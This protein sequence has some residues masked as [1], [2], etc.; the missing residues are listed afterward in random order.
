MNYF[1]NTYIFDF[2]GTIADTFPFFV[3]IASQM[4]LNTGRKAT[5]KDIELF[6]TTP[7]KELIKIYKLPLYKIPLFV[8]KGQQILSEKLDEI[9]IFPG[10]KEVLIRLKN[11]GVQLGMITS[12]NSKN[13]VYILQKYGLEKLFDFVHF[14]A[15]VFGK[16]KV[17]TNVIKK[18][19][20][21]IKSVIYVGD[22]VRDIEACKKINLKVIAVSW[23]Y[24][25]KKL[26]KESQPQ[27]IIAKPSDILGS[28]F[29]ELVE[30]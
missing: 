24:N 3:E 15:A 11:R 1:N 4:L 23:G 6:R 27:F 22:E 10:I 8:L 7:I 13:V 29:F 14:Q 19:K 30:K 18:Y 5:K 28:L 12:N 2:D 25:D 21:N 20:L 17:L 9:K 16:D 26:L